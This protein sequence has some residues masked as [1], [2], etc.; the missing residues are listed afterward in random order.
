M[1]FF[2]LLSLGSETLQNMDNTLSFS[3][4]LTGIS[5][6]Y[7]RYPWL[8]SSHCKLFNTNGTYAR[9]KICFCIYA[10]RFSY[11]R[12]HFW[13]QLW[14]H[15]NLHTTIFL[16]EPWFSFSKSY[17]SFIFV[18]FVSILICTYHRFR[19]WSILILGIVPKIPE[20]IYHFHRT[21]EVVPQWRFY[22]NGDSPLV[23][24]FY[25]H[26]QNEGYILSSLTHIDGLDASSDDFSAVHSYPNAFKPSR[27]WGFPL[28]LG[29]LFCDKHRLILCFLV[30]KRKK[31][32]IGSSIV[33]D[34][35]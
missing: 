2:I 9:T 17:F 19:Y 32:K 10:K 31:L 27:L 14:L 16:S 21:L 23:G 26:R 1:E 15:T 20:K 13:K 22:R 11:R 8:L 34:K 6:L 3:A 25:I 24:C 5:L 4:P 28:G 35:K 18:I 7:S 33:N 12:F 29:R 30:E